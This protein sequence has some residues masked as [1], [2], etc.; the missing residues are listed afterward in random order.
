M[1]NICA[2]LQ[3]I[4]GGF[5]MCQMVFDYIWSEALFPGIV[6]VCAG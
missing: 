5:S 3:A 1:K 4:P 6:F 2:K